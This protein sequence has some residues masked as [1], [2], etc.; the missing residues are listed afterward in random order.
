MLLAPTR[1]QRVCCSHQSDS[2]NSL[3]PIRFAIACVQTAQD[4]RYFALGNIRGE[5]YRGNWDLIF[6]AT[7]LVMCSTLSP[8]TITY[9]SISDTTVCFPMLSADFGRIRLCLDIR[10][11]TWRVWCAWSTRVTRVDHGLLKRG[12]SWVPFQ[13]GCFPMWLNAEFFDGT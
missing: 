5:I 13:L 9:R 10:L 4:G 3:P 11:Q 1:L 7:T 12:K 6:S 8:I 2:L